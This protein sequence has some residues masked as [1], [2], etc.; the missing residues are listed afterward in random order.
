MGVGLTYGS[1]QV[2]EIDRN[3][4]PVQAMHELAYFKNVYI[5][6]FNSDELFVQWSNSRLIRAIGHCSYTSSCKTFIRFKAAFPA[7]PQTPIAYWR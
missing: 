2:I 1:A 7:P 3:S 5:I 4:T 6:N